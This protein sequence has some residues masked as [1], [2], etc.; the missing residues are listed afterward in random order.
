MDKTLRNVIIVG[1]I[2]VSFSLGYYL[3]FFLPK[4]EAMRIKQQKREE[5]RINQQRQQE[6]EEKSAQSEKNKRQEVQKQQEKCDNYADDVKKRLEDKKIE[7]QDERLESIF[8]SPAL[9]ECV[10]AVNLSLTG[11]TFFMQRIVFQNAVTDA[12]YGSF[13]I[14]QNR[15]EKDK[16]DLRDFISRY[17][18]F[19]SD[20]WW[21]NL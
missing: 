19:S 18:P 5:I 11:P 4:K 15:T 20:N 12:V 1:I 8:F 2:I 9:N 3:V 6:E 17:V 16:Q 14:S 10:Y 7:G 21:E 13:E